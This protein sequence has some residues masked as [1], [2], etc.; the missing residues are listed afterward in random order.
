LTKHRVVNVTPERSAARLAR[1]L[2]PVLQDEGVD[3]EVARR[4]VDRVLNDTIA[5]GFS[6]GWQVKDA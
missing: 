2:M 5:G 1:V 4:I 3:P 6:M